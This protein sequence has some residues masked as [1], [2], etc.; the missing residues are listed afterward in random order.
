MITVIK[1]MVG[2]LRPYKLLTTLFFIGLFLDLA[3]VSLAPLSFKFMLDNAI[4]P[5]DYGQFY[6]ILTILGIAGLIGFS[7]GIMSDYM[8]SKLSSRV[9]KDLRSR[10][11]AHLQHANI[12]YFQRARASDLLSYLTGDLA[13]IDRAITVILTTGIQSVSVVLISAFVLFILEWSMAVFVLIGALLIFAGPYLLGGRAQ[14]VNA[15]YKEQ[16]SLVS[17]DIQENIKAQRVI[18]GFNLQ[19]IM[20]DK[21]NTRLQAMFVIDYKRNVINSNL[22]RIPM[23]SLLL[24]NF[25]I[26]GFG[27]YLALEGHI[28]V[29]ALVAFFTMYT[30]M[31]NSVFNLT[32]AIPSFTDAKVSMER[33]Q[34]LLDEQNEANG[35]SQLVIP[36][37]QQPDIRAAG[38]S[39]RYNDGQQDVLKAVD[40]YIPPGTTAAFVGSSG[41]GKSTMM[42]LILGFYEPGEGYIRINGRSLQ[43]LDKGSLREEI[44]IVFQ[45]NFLFRG[46]IMDNIRI[47][48]PLATEEEVVRAAAR[49]EIDDFIKSL[50]DGYDTEV[51]DDGSNFSGGQRQ[52]I[53]IARAILRDPPILLL[54]EATSALDPISEASINET[55]RHLSHNRTVVTVTHRLS[56][57]TEADGIFVFDQGELVESG[58]HKQ[59]LEAGGYYKELWDKQNGLSVSLSGEEAEIDE[60]RLSR[61]PF[62]RDMNIEVLSEIK[63]LF[64]TETFG[65]GDR[66]IHEGEAG[67]KFYIIARG[68]VEISKRPV[69]NAERTRLAVLADGDHFGEIALLE[70]VPRTADVTALTECTFLTL[71]RR[72]LH[73]VL[74]QYPELD[75]RVRDKLKERYN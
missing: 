72:V 43:E 19:Q 5:H 11:F 21:F 40:L 48:K 54:D 15:G 49:A 8:L 30:S 71:Q 53:A 47:S 25:T 2:Y 42:Q 33:I 32:F 12:A 6:F 41:S 31:G 10:L 34:R 17:G 16:M 45:D 55:F 13:A 39:F 38:L 66:V 1:N 37:G 18:K 61:L 14:A 26:I 35:A 4:V 22:E 20:I 27:S 63:G 68:K 59:M 44:G 29:G 3:F 46:T 52:R 23:I 74:S 7:S 9:Q 70:N 60:H 58:T 62:F 57:I 64:N 65:T 36:D 73:Y 67:N 24:I 75:S 69:G 56:A 28:T 51:L 50:P